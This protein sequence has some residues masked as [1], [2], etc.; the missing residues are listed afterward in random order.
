M[1]HVPRLLPLALAASVAAGGLASAQST[2]TPLVEQGDAVPGVGLVTSIERSAVNNS[3]EW[4]VVVDTDNQSSALDLVVLRNG[5]LIMQEGVINSGFDSPVGGWFYDVRQLEL[6]DAGELLAVLRGNRSDLTPVDLAVVA[7]RA[8][9]ETDVTPAPS[10]VPATYTHWSAI[11]MAWMNNSGQLLVS[12]SVND[13]PGGTNSARLLARFELDG[14]GGFTSQTTLAY[15]SQLLPGHDAYVQY[16]GNALTSCALNDAGKVLW[17]VDDEDTSLA[18]GA[19]GCCDTW[20]HLDA[21]PLI[22]EGAPTGLGTDNWNSFH[23][24]SVALGASGQWA[25]RFYTD[26]PSPA[27]YALVKNGTTLM[28]RSGDVVPGVDGSPTITQFAGRVSMTSDDQVIWQC[29]WPGPGTAIFRDDEVLVQKNVTTTGGDLIVNIPSN[30]WERSVSNDGTFITQEMTVARAGGNKVGC[31]LISLSPVAATLCVGD[32]SDGICP[33]ANLSAPGSG[34]G[35]ASSLGHG[36]LLTA[37]GTSQV[38]RDDLRFLVTQGRPNQPSMLVQGSSQ[39]APM[40]F[41]DGLLCLGN[42]T[43]RVEIVILDG[44]GAGSTTGSIV[45]GGG[46]SPGE[47]RYYQQWYRDPGGV[48]PCGFGSNFSNALQIDWI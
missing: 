42:P 26:E 7:G 45:T 47:T 39:V 4:A 41:K 27:N 2:I 37:L 28:H 40:P 17:L 35:C 48:S 14:L 15:A 44:D 23:S 1:Q 3:G 32:G 21:T 10:D 6:N 12:G 11:Q 25:G 38:A 29:T 16:P 19:N 43:E 20:Y 31:Y 18:G 34:E 13:G 46:V 24:S 22:R 9:V 30:L 8:I 5:S 36:A 33:C